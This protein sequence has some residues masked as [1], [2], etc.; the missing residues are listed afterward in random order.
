MVAVAKQ[1]FEKY[2]LGLALQERLD[3]TFN[4]GEIR[5]GFQSNSDIQP[6]IVSVYYFP[7][8]YLET[9]MGRSLT[10]DKSYER[11]I[12]ID[13]YMETEA[14]AESIADE[15]MDFLDET[16]VIVK[17]AAGD[18]IADL[19]CSDST[20]ILAQTLPPVMGQ[21]KVLRWRASIQAVLRADYII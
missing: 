17:N 19:Y 9:Q 15:I 3:P 21:G 11:H 2:A 18:Q 1:Y 10:T 13:A 16:N 6:P 4:V 8:H 20:T 12:Q 5:R 14:R 7:T